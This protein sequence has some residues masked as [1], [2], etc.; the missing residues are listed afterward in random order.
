MLDLQ[1]LALSLRQRLVVGDFHD[2]VGDIAA[3][4]PNQLFPRRV[5]VLDRVVENRRD[6]DT[7]VVD[8][9]LVREDI[10]Q[11]D[12]VIDVGG[13]ARIL[14]ALVPV[15]PG[16]ECNGLNQKVHGAHRLK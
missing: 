9:A 7:P 3:E 16:S 15:F 5:R 2:D 11:R 14:A 8:P 1:P 12:R 6:E 4:E 13:R 10:G